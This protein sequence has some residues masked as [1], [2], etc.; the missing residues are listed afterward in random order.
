MSGHG[1]D[2]APSRMDGVAISEDQVPGPTRSGLA[3]IVE[4][5]LIS[6]GRSPKDQ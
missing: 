5:E 6:G 2:A 3:H 1:A 4:V